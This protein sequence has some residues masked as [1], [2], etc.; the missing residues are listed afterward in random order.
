MSKIEVQYL[1]FSVLGYP[2]KFKYMVL[3]TNEI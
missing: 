1:K 2:I 3:L